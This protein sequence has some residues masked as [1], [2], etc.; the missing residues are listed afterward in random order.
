MTSLEYMQQLI[1]QM[2]PKMAYD[3]KSVTVKSV[4]ED[5]EIDFLLEQLVYIGIDKNQRFD[6]SFFRFQKSHS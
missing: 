5:L 3:E 2:V 6:F 1:S 4:F